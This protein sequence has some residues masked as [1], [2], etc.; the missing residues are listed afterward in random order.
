[1]NLNPSESQGGIN[2]PNGGA[3]QMSIQATLSIEPHQFMAAQ[4]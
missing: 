1:M 2:G 4:Q 3:F